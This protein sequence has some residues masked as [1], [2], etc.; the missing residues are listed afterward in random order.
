MENTKKKE[1]EGD[2]EGWEK[3][4]LADL[5]I[6][7]LWEDVSWSNDIAPSFRTQNGFQVFIM[8]KDKNKREFHNDVRFFV[9]HYNYYGYDFV[10]RRFDDFKEVINYVNQNTG[11]YIFK[12]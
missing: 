8:E 1:Y 10:C 4:C 12:Y 9:Q 5:D 6:P 7:K 2:Y 11:A 3:E